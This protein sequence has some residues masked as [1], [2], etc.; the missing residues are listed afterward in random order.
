MRLIG[1]S[2]LWLMVLMTTNHLCEAGSYSKIIQ[3][4]PEVQ[5]GVL[6]SYDLSEI[7]TKLFSLL[8]QAVDRTLIRHLVASC[9]SSEAQGRM[10]S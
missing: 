4:S 7:N 2:G 9:R 3:K 1:F 10:W 5:G 6:S 8:P